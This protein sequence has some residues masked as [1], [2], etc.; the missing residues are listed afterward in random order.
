MFE[1]KEFHL[2]LMVVISELSQKLWQRNRVNHHTQK[3]SLFV[4][5]GLTQLNVKLKPTK[6]IVFIICLHLGTSPQQEE[7]AW[8]VEHFIAYCPCRRF[9]STNV[10][11]VRE[12]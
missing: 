12:S 2:T 10:R 1:Q 3:L 11:N 8:H 9:T 5:F 6:S 4:A 7:L